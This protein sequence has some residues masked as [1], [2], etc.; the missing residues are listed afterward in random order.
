GAGGRAGGRVGGAGFLFYRAAAAAAPLGLAAVHAAAGVVPDDR[1][2]DQR[3]RL[4]QVRQA[5]QGGEVR[6]GGGHRPPAG[7]ER[8]QRHRRLHGRGDDRRRR[9]DDAVPVAARQRARGGQGA[10]HG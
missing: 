4:A 10:I 6:G 5:D 1:R 3:G 8:R 7:R 9:R 2:A